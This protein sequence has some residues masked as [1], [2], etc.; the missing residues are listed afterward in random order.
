MINKVKSTFIVQK[1]FSFTDERRKL[2]LIKYN[3][4]IQKLLNMNLINYR[5]F[6]GKYIIENKNGYCKIYDYNDNL[7]FEGEYLNGKKN[8]KGK[9]YSKN[10]ELLFEGEYLN[11]KKWNG[12][13]Y[14]VDIFNYKYVFR[15]WIMEAER[16]HKKNNYKIYYELNNGKGYMRDY[17]YE[18]SIYEGE[19]LNGERNGKGRDFKKFDSYLIMFYGE[20]LNGKRHGKGKEY[21]V[22]NEN[23]TNGKLIFEGEYLNGKRW[24]GKGYNEDLEVAYEIKNGNGYIKDIISEFIFEGELLDG[25]LNGK[26]KIY[27]VIG[28]DPFIFFEGEY[29]KGKK[30]GNGK[31]NHYRKKLIF[32]GEYLYNY[33]IK[34]KEYDCKGKLKYEGEYLFDQKW[35]GKGYDINGKVIYE[36]NNGTGKIKEYYDNGQLKFEGDYLNGKGKVKEYDYKGGILFEGEYKNGKRNG[37]GK[38]YFYNYHTVRLSLVFEGEFLNGDIWSGKY[39]DEDDDH[40]II[41]EGEILNG[42]ITGKAKLYW[43]GG[44]LIFDGEYLNGNRWNGKGRE[45]SKDHKFVFEGEYSN[46]KK[47]GKGK[48]F[49]FNG[50]IKFEG[51][52]LDSLKWNGKEYASGTDEVYEI[53]NGNGYIKEYDYAGLLIF[54][55]R[56]FKWKK[57][58]WKSLQY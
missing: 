54:E 45:I 17:D 11:G 24:N 28:P 1:I 6:S 10:G 35:S 3:K 15:D 4:D 52:Y 16:D 9:E 38:L 58:E 40:D 44:K 36:L 42:Q 26:V 32:E 51:D 29:L 43:V 47:N 22:N 56:I 49:Y 12:K 50:K 21:W 5:L 7:R 14:Y 20:Y 53:K 41:F 19:Y 31:E 57:M 25:E 39:N 23:D 27:S 37:K 8:G 2:E 30:H 33:K 34:G 46:G 55:R 48:E 13:A 18:E